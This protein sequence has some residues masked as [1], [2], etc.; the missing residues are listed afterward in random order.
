MLW[1]SDTEQDRNRCNAWNISKSLC[2]SNEEYP[3]EID[4]LHSGLS[5]SGEHNKCG[6]GLQ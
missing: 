6:Y 4:F 3:S 1:M 2:Q 5:K